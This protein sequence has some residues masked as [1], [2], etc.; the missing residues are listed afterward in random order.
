MSMLPLFRC[1]ANLGIAAVLLACAPDTPDGPKPERLKPNPPSS[2]RFVDAT[3]YS[4][5]DFL[6]RSGLTGRKYGVETIGSGAA[7]FDYDNDGRVDLYVVNGADLPGYVSESPPRNA[8]YKNAGSGRFTD[9]ALGQGVADTTY[10]M[11]IT[12]GDYDNDGDDDLF[13]TNYGPN[14]L[15]RNGP[16]QH[17]RF[18]DVADRVGVKGDSSWST[19]CAFADFDLDGDLDLYVANYLEYSLEA[20]ALEDDG[21]LRRPR[22]HLAPTEFPGRRDFLFR[23]DSGQFIDV[24]QAAG[25][26]SVSSRELGVI[27]LD[28]D[29]D[30]DPDLFQGNDATP[31]FLF[32]NDG[33]GSFTD[34]ALNVGV[35]YNE[36]GRPEGTMGVDAADVDGDGHIDLVMTNFQWESNTLYRNLANGRFA[37]ASVASGIAAASFD[38]LAF[39]INLFDADA[40]G[41]KDLFVANGHIDEDIERF[42]PQASYGQRDQLFLNDGAGT[43]TDVTDVAGPGFEHRLVG[44][45]SATADYDDDGDLDLFVV[46]VN[47]PA[48]LL[49]NDSRRQNHWLAL[50]LHGTHSNRNGYGARVLVQSGDLLQ[51]DEARSSSSYLSQDDPRLFF[52][53]GPH[54]TVDRLEITWPS[55][56]RQVISQVAVDRVL[57][58]HEPVKVEPLDREV[59]ET[60]Q[61]DTDT[62]GETAGSRGDASAVERAW[63]ESP[64][65]LPDP[66]LNK[67]SGVADRSGKSTSPANLSETDRLLQLAAALG[68]RGDFQGAEHSYRQAIELD[69]KLAAAWTGLGQ[70]YG[71]QGNP[72]AARTAFGRAILVDSTDAAPH[73][74]LG[75]LRARQQMFDR[76]VPHYERAIALDPEHVQAHIN[77]AAVHTRQTDYGPAQ[78][79][80]QRAIRFLPQVGDLLYRLGRIYFLQ[81]RYP[82]A[83]ATLNEALRLQPGIP[84]AYDLIAQIHIAEGSPEETHRTLVAGLGI[85]STAAALRTRLG[86][87]RFSEGQYSSAAGDLERAIR[88]NPDDEEAYY[89]LGHAWINLGHD[90]KGKAYLRCFR[91]LQEHHRDLLDHK[92]TILLNP[93]GVEGFYHLGAVYSRIDRFEAAQQAYAVALRIDPGHIDALNNMGNIYLRGGQVDAAIG[94]F[95]KVIERDPEYAKAYNNLGYAFLLAGDQ[96]RAV[97]QFE[98]AIRLDPDYAQARM[99]LAKVLRGRER[100]E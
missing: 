36:S 21:N 99:N 53:L 50:R 28:Y 54:Q 76:A 13:V 61:F 1:R 18:V 27:F 65:V 51:V 49:R 22:R 59:A 57:E 96:E 23:N 80:L 42:D 88:Q 81:A 73:Y 74:E 6:H 37:D 82:E 63:M 5:I 95:Q 4:G 75:N 17:G 92:T 64:M 56:T 94:A 58:V 7:F 33:A 70:T 66:V 72:E 39:G 30:G 83:L 67:G 48:V 31:N 35:A 69:A 34:V 52:G 26:E 38:R 46:N 71:R 68:D 10:G 85:D 47:Q 84:E 25:L 29:G 32:R 78:A 98:E 3:E 9:V 11:G 45:G 2:V 40:D 20:D 14:L 97:A 55:G 100:A 16:D 44:R 79:A 15:Y 12:V 86:A 60:P 87:L 43:F 90:L 24:T 89:L 91:R 19:G 8:L 93:N 77:L 41:D 62:I